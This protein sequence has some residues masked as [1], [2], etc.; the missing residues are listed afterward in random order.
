MTKTTVS[1][2]VLLWLAWLVVLLSFQWIVTTRLQIKHPTMPFSGRSPN[3]AVQQQRQELPARTISEPAGRLGFEYYVGIAVGGY[4]DPDAGA[5]VNPGTG[6]EVVK[7]YSFFPFYPYV[8]RAFALP[9]KILRL[10]PIATAS[11]AESL[12]LHWAHSRDCLPYGI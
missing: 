7:N 2:I 9:L 6:K 10:N 4:D 11:L 12:S 8:M 5:V 1:N 3:A